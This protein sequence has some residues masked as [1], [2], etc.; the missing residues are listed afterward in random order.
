MSEIDS[1][2]H[3]CIGMLSCPSSF[4]PMKRWQHPERAIPIY[5]L[6]EDAF[7]AHSLSGK[8]GDLLLGGGSGECPAL[9]VSIPEA[10][11]VY[12]HD[13]WADWSGLRSSEVVSV[14][15]WTMNYAFV[16]CEGYYR[17][18][19]QPMEDTIEVWLAEHILAFVL[20]EYPETYSCWQG[21]NVLERD[22]AI[23][24]KP[25]AEEREL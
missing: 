7:D 6:D 13:D 25:T 22:G 17:L 20:R 24:R 5:R 10:F 2:R 14:A 11:Y 15:Y 9:C 23:C 8:R 12:T 19:W 16:L 18:G 21:V 4:L 3:E 1:Y